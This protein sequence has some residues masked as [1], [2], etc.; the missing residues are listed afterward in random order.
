MM[1]RFIGIALALVAFGHAT[2]P[3]PVPDPKDLPPVLG[4]AIV[5]DAGKEAEPGEWEI[6]LTLP[7]IAWEVVGEVV[8]K[9]QWPELKAEVQMATLTLRMGGPSALAESRI[10]DLKGKALSR[11]EVVKRIVKATA[12]LISVSGRM[13]DAY[14]LQLTNPD[15]LIVLLGPR[16][17]CPAPEFLPAKTSVVPESRERHK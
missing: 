11:D 9:K 6:R 5:S 17:G 16:D 1:Q 7:K 15:A 10:V 14:F 4:M 12:V 3:D 8:P 13:P 2:A